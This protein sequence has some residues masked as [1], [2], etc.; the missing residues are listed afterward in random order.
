MQPEQ[1]L[2][3][4]WK[5]AI[6]GKVSA[7]YMTPDASFVAAGSADHD[8][9]LM[10]YSGKLL[11]ASTTGDEVKYVKVSDDGSCVA[12][13][14]TDNTVSYFDKH[15]NEVWTSR[16]SR[17]INSMDMSPDGT[18][19]AIGSEDGTLRVFNE[20][21]TLLWKKELQKPV[22]CV[23]I[24]ESGSLVMAGANT[25]KAYMFTRNG[26]LRWEFQA[27]SP[28][29]YVYTSD[30]GEVSYALEFTNNTL[31]QIS[32]RG[33]ELSSNT[34]SQRIVDISVTDDGRYLAIGFSSGFVYY[35]EK[36]GHLLWRQTV[37]GPVTSVK[38]SGDGSLVFVTAE[39][40][41]YILNKKGAMLLNHRFDGLAESAACSFD[42]DYV[43]VGAL[44]TVHMFALTKYV[45]YVIREQVKVAKMMKADEDRRYRPDTGS[46][47]AS[48]P[49]APDG[50]V[51]KCQSCG[52]PILPNRTLCNYC[53][54]M[55]RRGGMGR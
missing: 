36:N 20:R 35:T 7:I 50:G 11:W 48:Y 33:G 39:K 3:P 25:N 21:G 28:V 54:M 32:D 31:H 51:N 15:G 42:G 19:L 22:N 24:S 38:I 44:D 6:N 30:D 8:V 2:S 12:S 52:T 14:S 1:I 40:A 55:Q 13:Y 37:S 45:E 46:G 10:A 41:V 26:D 47:A 16:L 34:Y 43:A 29:L 9:Y 18:L 27:S 49:G 5:R 4:E 23:A 17:R 53:E